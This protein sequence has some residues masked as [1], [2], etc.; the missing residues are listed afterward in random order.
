MGNIVNISPFMRLPPDFSVAVDSSLTSAIHLGID[1]L[2]HAHRPVLWFIFYGDHLLIDEQFSE[3]NEQ[4]LKGFS[5]IPFTSENSLSISI[6]QSFCL[7]Y[8][9]DIP[10]WVGITSQTTLPENYR[11]SKLRGLF[12]YLEDTALAIGGYA[13]QRLEFERTHQFCGTCGAKNSPW[14]NGN[15][16]RCDICLTVVYPRIAPAMMVL[17]KQDTPR[18]RLLLLARNARFPGKMYS[19]LAGF[20]APS[21]SIEE[22]VHREVQEEVGL[23]VHH[24]KY[25]GSQAWPFPHSLMITFT[26]D[27]LAGEIVCQDDEIADAQWFSIDRLPSLPHRLSIARHLINTCIAEVDPEHPVLKYDS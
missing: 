17:I 4:T 2:N 13:L 5:G 14:E 8:L 27:Y 11:F 15:S 12:G 1:K 18:G 24:L 6:D 20:V 26:A 22:C 19:A 3:R 9:G 23:Q 16:K 7:A 10:C 21:E 25:H